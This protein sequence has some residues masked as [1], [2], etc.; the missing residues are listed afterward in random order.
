MVNRKT[1]SMGL[2]FIVSFGLLAALVWIMRKDIGSIWLILKNS[3]KAF[4]IIGVAINMPLT[5]LLAFRLK[6]LLA[7]QK[8]NIGM[9]D[10][11]SL[12]LIGFFFNNFLPTAIG[13]DIAKAYYTSKRTNNKL[14]SYAAILSDRLFGSIANIFI[15]SIGLIFIGRTL[16]NKA[17]LYGISFIFLVSVVATF[18]LFNK[19]AETQV[20][21]GKGILDKVKEKLYKLYSAI[22]TYRDHPFLLIKI[23]LLSIFMQVCGIVSIYCFVLSI[24]GV[25]PLL[26]LFL[27]I[28]LVWAVSMLP[29]INGL[30]VREGA[31]VYFLKND[32]GA[33][34]AFAISLL[35]LS[36]IIIYSIA[37]GITHLLYPVKGKIEDNP[38][39]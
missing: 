3:N 5:V 20:F 39:V 17:I 34:K 24:G 38:E 7:G 21:S 33:D 2:R 8:I 1:L 30:G 37:G 35:W 15:A 14:A 6:L 22:N 23:V 12:T 11:I 36:I 28:P 25:M 26:K 32:L 4:F 19:K 27:I 16:N 29:S 13:G 10:V 18:L 9:N 31:F